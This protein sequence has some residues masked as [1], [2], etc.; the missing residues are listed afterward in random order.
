MDQIKKFNKAVKIPHPVQA[1]EQLM[2]PAELHRVTVVLGRLAD[3]GDI[4]VDKALIDALVHMWDRKASVFRFGNCELTLTLEEIAG[5]LGIPL[6]DRGALIPSM[7]NRRTFCALLGLYDTAI[8]GGPE[9]TSVTVMFLF[10]HFATKECYHNH[11]DHFSL[12]NEDAW[13][14]K[15]ALVYGIV[16]AGTYLFPRPDGRI[17]FKLVKMIADLFFKV[18]SRDLSIVPIILADIFI[19]CTRCQDGT[20]FFYGS[21]F[22]L[23]LWAFEHFTRRNLLHLGSILEGYNWVKT[24]RRRTEDAPRRT[25]AEDYVYWFKGL[26]YHDVQWVLDW[27]DCHSPA[28]RT[29]RLQ[30]IPVV[31]SEGIASY[32]PKRVMRQF[33]RI[34]DIP[35][36]V[37]DQTLYSEFPQG[38]IPTPIPHRSEII[39]AWCTRGPG[40][41]DVF[42]AEEKTT[43]R[44]TPQYLDWFEST[45]VHPRQLRVMDP[46]TEVALLKAKLAAT[47][48]ELIQER[49]ERQRYQSA[50][51]ELRREHVHSKELERDRKRACIQMAADITGV[52]NRYAWE[53][54]DS[55]IQRYGDHL[56]K[57]QDELRALDDGRTSP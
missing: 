2:T 12:P 43:P 37:A 13:R 7:G 57:L 38:Q 15:R 23:Q 14:G 1:W 31:G 36:E 25:S 47:D 19:A 4:P 30:F 20:R 28:L 35:P 55:K 10:S 46:V 21:N 5:L 24:H 29:N 51:I 54:K 16:L 33:G 56:L 52:M 48:R 34:Q 50:Y 17:S 3:L 11:L 45:Y 32:I 6:K 27:T 26:K 42:V 18:D 44:T 8:P 41:D 49:T 53:S 9:A 39:E 22:I 40:A